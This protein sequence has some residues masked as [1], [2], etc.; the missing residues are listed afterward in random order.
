MFQ[1]AQSGGVLILPRID[2]DESSKEI[3]ANSQCESSYH[4][5]ASDPI[6][7]IPYFLC[8]EFQIQF[9]FKCHFKN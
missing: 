2:K 3:N 4:K 7:V 5:L 6:A 8:S 1:T 9:I